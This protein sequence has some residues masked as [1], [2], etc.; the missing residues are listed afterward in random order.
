MSSRPDAGVG[1]TTPWFASFWE[2]CAR[3]ASDRFGDEWHLSPE[4]S[5]QIHAEGTA[6][7]RQVVTYT[8]HGSNNTIELPFGTSLYDLM[9]SPMPSAEDLV[10]RHGL[11]LF[12][13]AA[14]LVRVPESFF[15][16][17]PVE[18]QVA[19]GSVADAS[20]VLRPLL[21]GG[22]STVAGRLAGA[23]RRVGREA[24]A[25]EILTTMRAAEYDV[26]ETDPFRPQQQ[27]RVVEARPG[28]I[29]SRITVLW[30]GMREHPI[31]RFPPPPGRPADP[32]A[33][34]EFV[35]DI[36]RS[37]AYHS[38][39]IEGYSVTPDLVEQVRAGDWDPE[40]RAQDR[41]QRDALAARG[42]WQAFQRVKRSVAAVLG[43]ADPGTVTREAH[44]AWYRELFQPLVAAGILPAASLAGY[45]TDPVYLRGSRHVPP[46]AEGLRDAMPALFDLL[47]NEPDP[48]AR[49]VLGHW[50][51][52]YLHPFPDG[53]GRI[54]RFLM[55]V[56]LASAGYPWTVI[57]VDDRDEYL[58][59]LETAS[60]ESDIKPFTDFLAER[61]R[62]SMDS[63]E[64]EGDSR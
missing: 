43:G 51:F 39:S 57:R 30:E 32:G 62:W 5:L 38:L 4:L 20:D 50:M 16:R 7:P 47:E 48:S 37:D 33:Y 6:I 25:D 14:A 18:A 13:P 8:P 44:R 29:V 42:Y 63:M 34:L 45:R 10:R 1:D 31:D 53:N 56:M 60:V 28:P 35:D 2:F 58:S 59:T 27:L 21:A 17:F 23:F 40:N 64:G 24:L 54:A 46:R 15:A 11:R 41:E 52:G 26:R 9:S 3:Y 36:Y 12:A 55:N 22:H 61:V 19:L 49:A